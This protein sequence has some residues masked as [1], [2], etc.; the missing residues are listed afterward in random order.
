MGA[1]YRK[2][3]RFHLTYSIWNYNRE[4]ERDRQIEAVRWAID[5]WQDATQFRFFPLPDRSE[6]DIELRWVDVPGGDHAW[7]NPPP[8]SAGQEPSDGNCWF[9]LNRSWTV[10]YR[11]DD[12]EPLDFLTLCA[13]EL[14][15]SIGIGHYCMFGVGLMTA[16]Y[17]GSVRELGP[18]DIGCYRHLY[19]PE[20][21]PD[22]CCAYFS[23]EQR[24]VTAC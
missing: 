20:R 9:N 3:D 21:E 4:L 8:T 19:E 7:A 12:R 17:R 1:E 24:E 6:A 13:H 23:E 14:G 11:E 18:T 2:W 22:S 16:P 15:H 10:E 5:L